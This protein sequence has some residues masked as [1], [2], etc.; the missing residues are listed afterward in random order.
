MA[1][2]DAEGRA[3]L[4]AGMWE[5][6]RVCDVR[7]GMGM[8]SDVGHQMML[9]FAATRSRRVGKGEAELLD[10]LVARGVAVDAQTPVYGYSVDIS[11]GAVAVEIWFGHGYPFRAPRHLRKTIDLANL[12]WSTIFV[13][14]SGRIPTADC[15]DAVVAFAEEAGRRPDS[16]GPQYRVVRSDGQFVTG[17]KADLDHI[18][19][20]PPPRRSAQA[21]E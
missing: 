8:R 9:T 14:C 11:V 16:V 18:A 20:V 7:A 15:A 19:L 2:L 3:K 12:G 1:S 6:T 17:G 13:W 21:R 10:L 4:A 5:K